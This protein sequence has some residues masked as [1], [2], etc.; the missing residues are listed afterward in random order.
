MKDKKRK[1]ALFSG[2]SFIALSASLALPSFSWFA[3]ARTNAELEGLSGSAHGSYFNGGNGSK[4]SP[5]EIHTPKQLYYFNWLQDLGYF[6]NPNEDKTA[7]NQVYF[8]LT[9]DL[10]MT[11]VVLPPA[12]T[13]TYPFVG[14]FDGNGKTVS[15]LTITNDE[16]SLKNAEPPKGAEYSGGVLKQAEIVGFFGVVGCLDDSGEVNNYTYDSSTNQILNM[17]FDGLNIISSSSATLVGLAAGYV[18]G[19]IKGVGIK[20][21][22][23]LT[24]EDVSPIT[25]VVGVKHISEY[26][27]VGYATEGYRSSLDVSDQS[28]SMPQIDNPNTEH[29]STNWGGSVNM[30]HMYTDLKSEI[31][32]SSI[33]KNVTY[34]TSETVDVSPEGIAGEPY[35]QIYGSNSF[36]RGDYS[37]RNGERKDGDGNIIASY[38]LPYQNLN[39]DKYIYIYGS[40]TGSSFS[41]S[42]TVTKNQYAYTS[43]ISKNG[44]YLSVNSSSKTITNTKNA[45]RAASWFMPET[46][47]SGQISTNIN[48]AIYYLACTTSYG[49]ALT[50]TSGTATWTYDAEKGNLSRK[51]PNCV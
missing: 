46:G 6:N 8:K 42:K 48:G 14:N 25:D 1:A 21:A 24:K 51:P 32:S 41:Y 16:T 30:K 35:D 40:Y 38:G 4:N 47:T 43:K 28:I 19:E 39:S 2:L 15:N 31:K 34:V 20:G 10:D 26:S 45:D 49:L 9:S 11:G 22:S 18:N 17:G 33:S 5:Y 7:I 23:I 12:G 37:Y 29:G 3:K 36:E 13:K 44:T 27:L 50:T